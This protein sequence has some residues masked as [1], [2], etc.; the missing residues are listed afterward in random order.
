[1]VEI[2]LVDGDVVPFRSI[3]YPR[4][5][6]LGK[7][8]LIYEENSLIVFACKLQCIPALLLPLQVLLPLV[9]ACTLV[10]FHNLSRNV[11]LAIKSAQLHR[12]DAL[13]GELPVEEDTPLDKTLPSPL[14]KRSR[15]DQECDVF[16]FQLSVWIIFLSF[17]LCRKLWSITYSSRLYVGDVEML[18]NS[19]HLHERICIVCRFQSSVA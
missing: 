6:L 1:M 19:G 9:H 15:I 2:A 17:F 8:E 18:C 10:S 5:S 3:I 11:V 4:D 7:N 16:F 13:I 12:T 14:L